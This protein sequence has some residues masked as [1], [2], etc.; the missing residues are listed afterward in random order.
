MAPIQF[1]WV[2][3]S[4]SGKL[5]KHRSTINTHLSAHKQQKKQQRKLSTDEAESA[6][7]R[8]RPIRPS[9]GDTEES[10]PNLKFLFSVDASKM[11]PFASFSDTTE[12]RY[13]DEVLNFGKCN[14]YCVNRVS[15]H[16]NQTSKAVRYMWPQL[17]PSVDASGLYPVCQAWIQSCMASPMTFYSFLFGA[18][19]NRH[20]LM[21][22]R[23]IDKQEAWLRL[24][25][26]TKAIQFIN[27]EISTM[28]GN[29]PMSF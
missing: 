24:F 1:T 5:K 25:F 16:T 6:P 7:S 4:P 15:R 27:H 10:L 28:Q 12:T 23:S 11:D 9:T 26:K 18:S 20:H 13:V 22:S 2:P 14:Q 29:L 21:G 19:T 8:Y 3:Q 17:V